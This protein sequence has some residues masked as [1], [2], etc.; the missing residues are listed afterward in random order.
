M[1]HGVNDVLSRAHSKV[2]GR[3]AV[4]MKVAALRVVGS[5][6]KPIGRISGVG[7]RPL[8][9]ARSASSPSATATRVTRVTA[10]TIIVSLLTRVPR[11]IGPLVSSPELLPSTARRGESPHPSD[12][13]GCYRPELSVFRWRTGLW[14]LHAS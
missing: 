11:F 13:V 1:P 12:T 2:T 6:G 4:N 7:G 10:Q 3:A 14:F 9:L 8:P 5:F